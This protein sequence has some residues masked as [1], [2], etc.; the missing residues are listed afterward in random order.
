MTENQEDDARHE[1]AQDFLDHARVVDEAVQADNIP[2]L[3][4]HIALTLFRLTQ[5]QERLVALAQVDLEQQIEAEIQSR[6]ETMAEEIVE[7]K[8]KRGFIGKRKS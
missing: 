2:A 6:A 4:G 1:E 8:T 7:D 3:M 5:A